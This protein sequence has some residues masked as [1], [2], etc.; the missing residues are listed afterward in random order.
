MP[1][2][3]M[4]TDVKSPTSL[5][6]LTLSA[7]VW[8]GLRTQKQWLSQQKY[9]LPSADLAMSVTLSPLMGRMVRVRVWLSK[10]STPF[11]CP[12][13]R[14]PSPSS[15]R[16]VTFPEA[17]HSRAA[18][19][20]LPTRHMCQMFFPSKVQMPLPSDR[21]TKQAMFMCS[22]LPMP[23]PLA[24][25]VCPVLL[26]TTVSISRSKPSHIHS[27]LSCSSLTLLHTVG[28]PS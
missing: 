11:S 14:C 16:L 1:L 25:S 15:I 8:L 24:H 27:V 12:M 23:A 6:T 7:C 4:H 19:I 18:L 26:F 28:L 21:L 22:K 2:W 10:Q 13:Y 3:S 9:R 17:S 20:S 5:S